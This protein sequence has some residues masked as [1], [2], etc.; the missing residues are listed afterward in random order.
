LVVLRHPSQAQGL[1]LD[2][3]KLLERPASSHSPGSGSFSRTM[4]VS[5]LSCFWNRCSVLVF[6]LTEGN[7]LCLRFCNEVP[8]PCT[9]ALVQALVVLRHP[10]QAQGLCL[11]RYKLL[12]RPASSRS[13]GSDS[14][15]RTMTVS[16]FR[17]FWNRCSVLVF[18]LTEGNFLCPRPCN[19]TPLFRPPAS[20]HWTTFCP[21]AYHGC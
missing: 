2:R 16:E 5:E 12:E 17:C 8:L 6:R 19:H 11:D 18:R 1:C 14:F 13:P 20:Q 3:D 21:G 7:L 9:V 15:S 10:S 4:T